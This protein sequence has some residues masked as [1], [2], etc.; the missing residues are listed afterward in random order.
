MCLPRAVSLG[1]WNFPF[2]HLSHGHYVA[3]YLFVWFYF[4][5]D[6]GEF[7]FLHPIWCLVAVLR[8]HGFDRQRIWHTNWCWDR[9]LRL[10]YRS[11]K[12]RA[13]GHHLLVFDYCQR[14]GKHGVSLFPQSLALVLFRG[15]SSPRLGLSVA[16][17]ILDCPKFRM[18]AL[19]VDFGWVFGAVTDSVL[20]LIWHILSLI[21]LV[22]S[23]IGI[24]WALFDVLLSQCG[25]V[26]RVLCI[27]IL[28]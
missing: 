26:A 7:S 25:L 8:W 5:W 11:M 14:I 4:F 28:L 20:S 2:S 18:L 10:F 21:R 13:I 17:V 23:L 27:G 24:V 12:T 3:W 19:R 22:L 9:F 1:W 15:P 6:N 16:W